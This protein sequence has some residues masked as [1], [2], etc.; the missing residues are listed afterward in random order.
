MKYKRLLYFIFA[1]VILAALNGQR[2]PVRA[3]FPDECTSGIYCTGPCDTVWYPPNNCACEAQGCNYYYQCGSQVAKNCCP[4]SDQLPGDP[5]PY[6]SCATCQTCTVCGGTGII[7]GTCPSQSNPCLN[8]CSGATPTPTPTIAPPPPTCP[9]GTCNTALGENCANCWQDCQA[10]PV[11][12]ATPTP[13]PPGTCPNGTCGAG[14]DCGNCSS[15]CGTCPGVPPCNPDLWGAYGSCSGSPATKTRTNACGN[16]QTTSC[17]GSIQARA[18]RVNSSLISCSDVRASTT[19]INGAIHQFTAGSASQPAAQTQSGASY[20]TF[21]GVVG[22]SYTISPTVPSTYVLARAC[23]SRTLNAPTSGEGLTTTL[24]EPTDSETLTWD[25]GYRLGVPWVQTE[26]GDVYAAGALTSSI[27]SGTSPRSFILDGTGGYPGVAIY[28][29]SYDFDSDPTLTGG[30]FVSSY[31]WLVN[32]THSPVVNYYEY[33]RIKLGGPIT[34]STIGEMGSSQE[35]M[36]KPP[37]RTTPYYVVGDMTTSGDWTIP[38]GETVIFIVNG[39][40]TLGGKVNLTGSGFAAFIVN[41]NITISSSVGGLSTSSTPVIEGIYVTSKTGTFQTGTSTVVG[42]ERLVGQGMFVAGSF[43]LQRDLDSVNQNTTTSS[44]L[45]L[46]NPRLLFSMPDSMR[47]VPITW[48]E[49]AP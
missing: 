14:E 36:S 15:D 42:K 33:F 11:V 6:Q 24:S 40:L 19:G 20:V 47:D 1:F 44:E 37:S 32:E 28:G 27:P 46:Y 41:G 18:V 21:G 4:A 49:V 38:D 5:Y 17:T 12:G 13:P 16:P 9:D 23:W 31:D 35:S 45:F 8:V 3:A 34:P 22:G 26:G 10:C 2:N 39:N 43:L 48:A 7:Q 29:T 30:T 25:L